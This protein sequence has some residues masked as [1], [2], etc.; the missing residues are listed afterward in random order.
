MQ[1][2]KGLETEKGWSN[3]KNAQDKKIK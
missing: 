3:N 1:A 2:K